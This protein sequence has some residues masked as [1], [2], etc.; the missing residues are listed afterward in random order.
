MDASPT[1]EADTELPVRWQRVVKACSVLALVWV[2][3]ARMTGPSDAWDQAQPQTMSYTTDIVVNGNWILPVRPNGEKATKPPLYNWL[4]APAVRLAGFS[5]ELAHKLPSV[6]ALCLCWLIVLRVGSRMDPTANGVLGWL[7]ATFVVANYSFFKLGYLARPDMLL[8]LWLLLGWAAATS[9]L[10]DGRHGAQQ[11]ASWRAIVF[12]LCTGLAAL[13]KGPA[14]LMLPVYA[15]AAA[16]V[17]AGRWRAVNATGWWWGIPL[18][19]TVFGAWVWGVWRIDRSQ[20]VDVLWG[21]EIAGRVT[22]RGPVGVSS[23]PE[24]LLTTA[25]NMGLYYLGF[26]APWSV[27]SLFAMVRLWRRPQRDAARR[28]RQMRARGATLA[29]A[30]IF[31]IV[32]VVFYSLSA[33]KRADYAAGAYAPGALLAAWWLL[34]GPRRLGSSAPWLAPMATL[35]ALVGLTIHSR[36]EYSSPQKGFGDAIER[37]IRQAEANVIGEAAP[38]AYWVVDCSHLESYLGSTRRD[39]EASVSEMVKAGRPFW[40]FSGAPPNP[41]RTVRAWLRDTRYGGSIT[42]V[43]RSDFLTWSQ[44]WPG[45]VILFRVDPGEPLEADQELKSREP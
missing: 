4:A 33:S 7:A 10:V 22:G 32:I 36:G 14:A 39:D 9:L 17:I 40:L 8:T 3:A 25:A 44:H 5:S 18:A 19:A 26:F 41:G 38:R 2:L 24:A 28:W 37:F 35:I 21:R 43:C 34:E 30:A 1:H 12:W 42:E 16:P 20:L 27:L 23:G 11:G 45:R 31:V 15:I 13:T 29:G 6:V